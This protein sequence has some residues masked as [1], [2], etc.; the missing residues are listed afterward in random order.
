M[1]ALTDLMNPVAVNLRVSRLRVINDTFQKALGFQFGGPNVQKAPGGMDRGMYDVFNE[2]REVPGARSHDSHAATIA[3]QK[4]GSVGYVIPRSAEKMPLLLRQLTQIRAIG[5]PG[6]EV[7]KGGEKY[8]ALQEKILKQRMV[9]LREFQTA[10]MMRGS[11]TFSQSGDNLVHAFSGGTHTV[12]YQIPSTNK[13]QLDMLGAGSI[14]GTSWANNAAPIITNLLMIDKAFTQL[15]GRG[16]AHIYCNSTIWNHVLNNQQVQNLAGAVNNP[17]KEY[18]RDDN[19]Q[20][21]TATING[22]P[23]FTFHV[24]NN[25]VS[26]AGTFTLLIPDTMAIFT[27]EMG[28]EIAAYYECDEYVVDYVGRAPQPRQGAYFWAVA[29]KDPARYDLHSIHNGLPVVFIPSAMAP[30]TVVF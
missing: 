18:R 20:E 28:P 22:M 21:F 13:S 10:A 1:P 29:E 4:T 30:G 16:L 19:T 2:T 23:F 5:G 12:N 17:V 25:G 15:T 11:Y 9:N 24:S 3:P 6:G 26:L 14:I 27:V 8:I 7:D